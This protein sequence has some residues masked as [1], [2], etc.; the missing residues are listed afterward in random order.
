MFSKG[1]ARTIGVCFDFQ[2]FPEVPVDPWDVVV[3]EVI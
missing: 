1:S 2:K 3:D